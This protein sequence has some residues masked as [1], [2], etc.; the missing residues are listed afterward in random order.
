MMEDSTDA[1]RGANATHRIS[2]ELVEECDGRA[3]FGDQFSIWHRRLRRCRTT[4]PHG[5]CVVAKGAAGRACAP[6][7][8]DMLF[9]TLSNI[10]ALSSRHKG[11]RTYY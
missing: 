1:V 5:V 8:W 11:G 4:E 3:G 10:E 7:S 2:P 9:P 6:G